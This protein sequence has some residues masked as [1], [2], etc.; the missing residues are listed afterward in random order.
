MDPVQFKA[1]MKQV[2]ALIPES[3]GI[4]YWDVIKAYMPVAYNA[5]SGYERSDAQVALLELKAKGKV[6]WTDEG[7]VSRRGILG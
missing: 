5:G 7:I 4:R 2:L 6:V 3:G 1:V